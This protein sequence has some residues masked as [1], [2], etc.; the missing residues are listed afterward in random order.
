MAS[1]PMLTADALTVKRWEMTG[2]LNV[3]QSTALGRMFDNGAVYFPEEFLGKD[4]KGDQVTY[5]YI[6]K[7]TGHPIGEG[8]V[9]D[10]NEKALDLGSFSMVINETRDAVLIPSSGIEPQRAKLNMEK[11]AKTVLP[12]RAAELI[13]T[14]VFQQLAGVN[15]TSF[16]MNGTTYDSAARKLHVQGHNTIV[17]PSS[18]RIVR[19]AAAATDQA[20]TSSDKMT[21]QLIDYAMELNAVSDQP[22]EPLDNGD[23]DLYLHPYQI[24]DL[25][26]DA[27]SAIQWN[28]IELARLEGGKKNDFDGKFGN[29]M[30]RVIGKYGNINLIEHNRVAQG[31]TNDTGAVI[32]TVRRAVLVGKNALTFASPYGGR[33]D[34]DD[35][36]LK[37]VDQL[38]DYKKYKGLGFELLYGLKKCVATT[39]SGSTPQDIGVC[40]IGT[41]AAAHT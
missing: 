40:V 22:M 10:G 36:P 15:P 29:K 27:T 41:Y 33:P 4:T 9:L 17:V 13:D 31:A 35:V 2:W 14:G 30:P 16:T 5:D 20:I 38:K 28:A 12:A 3:G 1:T 24:V 21:L 39:Q 34:D 7:M 18:S 25:R 6:G 32:T 37:I 26:L 19:A 8:G 11:A 23:F